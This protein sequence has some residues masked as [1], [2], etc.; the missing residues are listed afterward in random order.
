MYDVCFQNKYGGEY[1]STKKKKKRKKK[2]LK[3][4]KKKLQLMT[5]LKFN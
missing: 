4:Q 3:K 2:K 1:M 5:F